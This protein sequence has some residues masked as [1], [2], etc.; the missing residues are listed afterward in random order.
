MPRNNKFDA[1]FAVS[2]SDIGESQDGD[3]NTLIRTNA[4]IGNFLGKAN[5]TEG[6]H[7]IGFSY[8]HLYADG[9]NQDFNQLDG[10]QVG[11]FPGFAGWG[12]WRHHN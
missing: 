10:P 4:Q 9:E 11:R 1:L 12:C 8:Q 5:Y 6:A 2:Y 7:T 3:G